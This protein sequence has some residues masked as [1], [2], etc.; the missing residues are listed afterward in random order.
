ML[1]SIRAAFTTFFRPQS[2]S[3]AHSSPRATSAGTRRGQSGRRLSRAASAAVESLETRTLLATIV[4]NSVV[5]QDL[6]NVGLISL[7]DAI[8]AAN[9][10][11]GPDTITFA[12]S[13]TAGGA[14]EFPLL[15]GQMQ[16][17]DTSGKTTINGP[18]SNLMFI[19]GNATSRIFNIA[20]GVSVDMRDLTLTNG[21][22]SGSQ[23]P[24]S[25]GGAIFNAG[26]LTVLGTTFSS[27]Q[28][29]GDNSDGRGGAIYTEGP[30]TVTASLFSG[31]SAN[32]SGG[33][34][35]NNGS[36]GNPVIVS[37]VTFS[38]NSA[39]SGGGLRNTGGALTISG[40]GF[41]SNTAPGGDGGGL[42]TG[43][44]V[45]ITGSNFSGNSSDH[46]GGISLN[47]GGTLTLNTTDL[48]NNTAKGGGGIFSQGTLT[49]TN[50]TFH[51]NEVTFGGQHQQ[52]RRRH[53]W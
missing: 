47:F 14:T 5:D 29:Q 18:G 17:T 31:N 16:I 52:Q 9:T 35:D 42:S 49:V 4:V 28:A 15:R 46:G 10:T 24:N 40:S 38:T 37:G 43:G 20:S 19:N 12:P 21:K 25:Q 6:T 51:A 44:T 45:T 2:L 8:T 50:S 33:A 13:L 23:S 48:S 3:Q 39:P 30:L 7:R 1:N 32:E 26:T 41:V 34:I 22:A 36:I 11:P 53:R 27:N